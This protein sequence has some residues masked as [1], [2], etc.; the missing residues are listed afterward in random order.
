MVPTASAPAPPSCSCAVVHMKILLLLLACGGLPSTPR[1]GSAPGTVP[2]DG[3]RSG[4]AP[5]AGILANDE[6]LRPR[7]LGHAPDGLSLPP[8]VDPPNRH[9]NAQG[10]HVEAMAWEPG[11]GGSGGGEHGRSPAAV[12]TT[13]PSKYANSLQHYGYYFGPQLNELDTVSDHSNVAF[14]D[15][16]GEVLL[17][18][19]SH[20]AGSPSIGNCTN[21]YAMCGIPL[22][23]AEAIA[24]L[25]ALAAVNMKGVL[26]V[27]T[28]FMADVK[29]LLPIYKARWDL[30]WSLVS[31]H[32]D[33]IL[34]IY[35]EDEPPQT[36]PPTGA[37]TEMVAYINQSTPPVPPMTAVLSGGRVKGIECAMNASACA[38]PWPQS[39][40]PVKF[41]SPPTHTLDRFNG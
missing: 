26:L 10:R 24:N 32:A 17:T 3:R 7:E 36:W 29:V 22:M 33:A 40:V 30:F 2:R 27:Q 37:Y 41:C 38:G 1:A 34:T 23:A 6:L 13:P 14:V 9:A 18:A 4:A 8:L 19:L 15:P 28:V 16:G 35:P 11:S 20:P 12:S 25:T 31:P 39:A 21:I 5:Q